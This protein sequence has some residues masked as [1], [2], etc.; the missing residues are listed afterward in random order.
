MA[1]L[2]AAA[3]TMM[4]EELLHRPA[5][6]VG[7]ILTAASAVLA[8]LLV[9]N[10]LL[11][12]QFFVGFVLID[13]R[14]LYALATLIL[15][16][17]FLAFPAGAG[18]R[19][20]GV[21]WYDA[22]L[23]FLTFA[24]GAWLSFSAARALEEGWEY[25]APSHAIWASAVFIV[26]ILEALRRAGGLLIA[27]IVLAVALYPVVA[28]QMPGPIRGLAQPLPDAIAFHILSAESAFGIPM[29]AFGEIV[30][31]FIV[32]GVALNHTGGGKFF[33]DVAFALVGRVR[34]GAAQVGVISSALQ[35]SI[36]GS[37]ISNVIS[38]G[39]VTIPAMKR[40]GFS[41]EYAGAVEAV[42]STG[43]VLMPPVMGSTAFVMASFLGKPYAEIALAAAVPGLL[44]YFGLM[45]QVD[46]YAAR[47]R[48]A[49]LARRELPRLGATL[50]EGWQYIFVFVVLVYFMLNERQEAIA[51]FIATGLLLAINQAVPR[52][53]MDRQRFLEFLTA[54]GRELASLVAVLT[55]IGF[56][57]GSFAMTG[58]SGTLVNDLV[59]LAGDRPVVL[60]VMGAITSFIFGMGMTV[61]ACYI[62]LAIVLVPP[63][64]KAG[65]D[66][67]AVHLFVMYWGMIS[68]ITPPVALA[69]FAAAP[70]AKTG[71]FRIGMQSMRLGTIIYIVPF[72]FVLNPALVL[73]GTWQEIVLA[74]AP[75]FAGVF[76]VASAL[77]GYLIGAGPMQA[78][79]AG[80]LARALL[81]AGGLVLL[82]PTGTEV[83]A[84]W[85]RD[86]VL[87]HAVDLVGVVLGAVSF[88][89]LRLDRSAA[90]L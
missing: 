57:V 64:V 1:D 48:L 77:Q 62:F 45:V 23:A 69:A 59:Y 31:G 32:F 51:P 84:W 44:F 30:V 40:T 75:A 53:R 86:P 38:S 88:G 25:A 8:V 49:G 80:V 14:Y 50:A 82:F 66:P 33:N 29:R 2:P 19:P 20:G 39:V 85:P 89:L 67:L 78:T 10:Q 41:S 72:V 56:I 87:R 3:P 43:A 4:P 6:G 55:G 12:L 65:L 37:V 34:G 24:V 21:P 70:I 46:A 11:N 36:S 7:G 81:L 47:R 5:I 27:L 90:V 42:A 18:A 76:A 71:F 58:L 73:H 13:P 68:F 35:G 83:L 61:T 63:L 28:A 74:L 54:L 16:V 15:P 79:P 17:T 52:H 9:L 26:L 22:M 60:L